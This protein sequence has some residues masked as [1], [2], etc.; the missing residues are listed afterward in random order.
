MKKEGRKGEKKKHTLTNKDVK[1]EKF[2]YEKGKGKINK[3]EKP[4]SIHT[5]LHS[6]GKTSCNHISY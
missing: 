1:K 3:A 2:E 6:Y 4:L 5:K